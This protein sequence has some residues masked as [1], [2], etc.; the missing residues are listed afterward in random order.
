MVHV[1]YKLI[2]VY[3]FLITVRGEFQIREDGVLARRL[4]EEE[5][6][7]LIF[8]EG[9][10]VRGVSVGLIITYYTSEMRTPL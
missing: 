6:K 9:V 3:I 5:C 10:S 8:K 2:H 7:C 1:I 4:Q